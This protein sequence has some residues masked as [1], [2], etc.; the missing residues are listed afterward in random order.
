MKSASDK[1]ILFVV[2][3]ASADL[4]ASNLIK[5]LREKDTRIKI[6]GVG[7]P[8]MQSARAELICD[9]TRF[10]SAG[11][12]PLRHL[13]KFGLVFR[14]LISLVQKERPN[15]IVLVDFP[16]FNLR[17]AKALKGYQI[18]IVYYIS[19]QVWAWRQ[20][21][22]KTMAKLID[23]MI[24]IFGFE[25][26]LYQKHG[27][28]VEYVGHPLLDVIKEPKSAD[29]LV[30]RRQLGIK[31]DPPACLSA[32]TAGEAGDLVIGLLPGSRQKEF[33]RHLPLM[34]QALK[35][36]REDVPDFRVI[37]GCAPHIKP[38]L[39]NRFIK[40]SALLIKPF[41]N[42]A[43]EVMQGSD[44]LIVS[45]GTVTV[46]A[47]I[48]GKPMVVIY[49]LPQLT[50]SVLKSMVKKMPCYAMVNIIAGKKIV[51]ELIQA[52]ATPKHI[53]QEVSRLL[54]D[55]QLSKV[56]RELRSVRT[57]LGSSGASQ[58][59]ANTILERL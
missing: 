15:L 25:K 54:K 59:A 11:L 16:D 56:I 3:E 24:V 27:I 41:Y 51:P 6:I 29:R 38:D 45:S 31:T 47:A 20:G 44:L 9:F 7:G 57:K 52:Q 34:L 46:E 14:Q 5:A 36:L 40:S 39:V 43:F 53:Y 17:L 26:E 4:H 23:L 2:G 58:R 49:K 30:A 21:R 37:I 19:P 50:A 42:R 55:D 10:A 22:I 1:K 32:D 28:P 18:P 48:L 12:D 35:R 13:T 8:R 33:S